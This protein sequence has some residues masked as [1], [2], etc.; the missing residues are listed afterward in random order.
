MARAP[1]LKVFSTPVGF[2]DAI[3]AAPSQA[4]ALRAWG[5]TTNL[6]ATGTA[7]VVDDEALQAE[8]LARPGEVVKRARGDEAAMLGP[9][10][11]ERFEPRPDDEPAPKRAKGRPVAKREPAPPLPDRSALDQAERAL[12]EAERAL[13]SEIEAFAA[14]RAD[15]ERRERW[16]RSQG[17]ARLAELGRAKD[18]AE[19]TYTR[20]VERSAKRGR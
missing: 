7:C 14:E 13:S 2:Y 12:V 17:D 4:A 10:P 11:A 5:T 19:T 8:A 16:A 20:A 6:F 1:K 9:E 3:V 15:L 18:D